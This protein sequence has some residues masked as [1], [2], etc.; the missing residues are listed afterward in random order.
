VFNSIGTPLAKLRAARIF[1]KSTAQEKSPAVT[2]GLFVF[3]KAALL[4][5]R[6]RNEL[7]NQAFVGLESLLGEVGVET[8]DLLGFGNEGLVS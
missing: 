7:G 2:A 4:V 3:E 5:R 1:P 6:G 8:R